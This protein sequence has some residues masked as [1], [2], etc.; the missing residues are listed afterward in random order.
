M[1]MPF[2][3]RFSRKNEPRSMTLNRRRFSSMAQTPFRIHSVGAGFDPDTK[4][5]GTGTL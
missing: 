3:Q 4:S 5:T 1:N 2:T